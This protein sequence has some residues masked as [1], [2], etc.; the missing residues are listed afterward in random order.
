LAEAIQRGRDA[1]AVSSEEGAGSVSNEKGADSLDQGKDSKT[2]RPEGVPEDWK[3][4]P[5]KKE[6]NAKWVNPNN[7]HDYVRAKPD[8]TVTQVRD[9]KAYD[10]DGNRVDLKSPGAHGI[11]PDRFIFR[12]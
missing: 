10:A 11:T 2:Q 5:G 12:P 7:P 3:E 1:L 6:G 8:G 9:G 4:E